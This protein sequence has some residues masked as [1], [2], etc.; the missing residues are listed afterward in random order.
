[1]DLVRYYQAASK[2]VPAK[3][4]VRAEFKQQYGKVVRWLQ[5]IC[6]LPRCLWSITGSEA[7]AEWVLSDLPSLSNF[8]VR[9]CRVSTS[10][11][12]LTTEGKY[13]KLGSQAR[14][15]RRAPQKRPRAAQPPAEA[16]G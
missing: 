6:S 10:A 11:T 16:E 7:D 13:W 5:R 15:L 14:L 1:M 12:K 3:V 8:L 2:E 4:F 9:I